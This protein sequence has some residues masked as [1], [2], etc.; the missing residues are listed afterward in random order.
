MA[1]NILTDR[2]T[3]TQILAPAPTSRCVSCNP[4]Q[5]SRGPLRDMPHAHFCP[6]HPHRAAS[7][8]NGN[9]TGRLNRKCFSA[10]DK[11]ALTGRP[12]QILP[13]LPGGLHKSCRPY[14]AAFTNPAALTGRHS[15][16]PPPGKGGFGW[17]TARIRRPS[18]TRR[19]AARSQQ[20]QPISASRTA[21]GDVPYADRPS[22]ARPHA[23][24]A[25]RT[26][27]STVRV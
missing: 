14:R 22:C 2:N 18:A 21:C 3:G 24:H 27:R 7:L 25:S 20:P 12:S 1:G 9:R 11:A 16:I 6:K 23:H 15:Q 10:D 17:L 4:R 13:P 26:Q 19:H 5:C 8:D